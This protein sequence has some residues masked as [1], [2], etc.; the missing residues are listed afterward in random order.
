M[1]DHGTKQ[2]RGHE[3]HVR[4]VDVETVPYVREMSYEFELH[5]DGEFIT[6]ATHIEHQAGFENPWVPAL[7]RYGRAYVNGKEGVTQ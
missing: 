7:F 5:I 3:L 1:D 4:R 6:T 2:H